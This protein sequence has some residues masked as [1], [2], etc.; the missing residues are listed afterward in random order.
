MGFQPNWNEVQ[1]EHKWGVLSKQ[2][3]FLLWAVYTSVGGMMLGYDFG[4]AGTATAMSAFQRQM[5]EVYPSQPSGYLIPARIQSGWFAASAAGDGVGSVMAGLLLGWIGRKHV[6]GVGSVITAIGVAIQVAAK[7]WNLFLAGRFI[8]AIG[9]GAVYIVSPVW[10]GENSRPELRGFFLCFMN[11]SVVFGQFLLA[12]IS[13]GSSTIVGEWSYQTVIVLQ[14][15]Y[16][17]ILLAVYPFFPESPYFLLQKGDAKR[18]R[19]SLVRIHG[20]DDQVLIDA[21]VARIQSNVIASE[22]VKRAA[23]NKGPLL[24][25]CFTGTN[26]KRTMIAIIPAAGQQLIGATFVLGYITYF[27]GLIGVKDNFTVTM[28]LYVVNLLSNL[29][30]FFLIEWVGRRTLLVYGVFFLTFIL[31]IMGIMG[32]INTMGAIWFT[33][34]CIFL[35][36]L[37]YEATIGAIGFAVASEISSLP[38][39]ATV[40]SIIGMSS[41][42]AAWVIGFTTPYMINPDAGD[43]GPKVGFVFFGLGVPL[44]ISLFFLV[45]ETKGLSF[46]EVRASTISFREIPRSKILVEKLST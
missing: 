18:A 27:L 1:P 26:L 38:L 12:V 31:L 46:D 23:E 21:E 24:Q 10:M 17:A 40:Q 8:N 37:V 35:W 45:P 5:G 15:L 41:V 4:V 7:S 25:Q 39:R 33:V 42:I 11:G 30:A 3:R 19:E 2:K 29:S 34:V 20:S 44:S 28:I 16:V 6:I 32:C 13:R 43:L 22:E 14:F 9:Y 36:S